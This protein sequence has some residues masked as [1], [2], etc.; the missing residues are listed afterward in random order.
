MVASNSGV[1]SDMAHDLNQCIWTKIHPPEN[2]GRE[3][4]RINDI[5]LLD[6]GFYSLVP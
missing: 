6:V 2:P 1:S 5:V 4:E 3:Y